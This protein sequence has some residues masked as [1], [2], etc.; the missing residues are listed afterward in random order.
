[1]EKHPLHMKIPD[2]QTSE[3]VTDAVEKKERLT[4][5][6]LPNDPAARIEAYMGRL[7]KIFL[8]TDKRVRERNLEMLRDNTYDAFIIRP[9]E[10]PESYFELQRK[11]ARERG[12]AVEEIPQNVRDQMIETIIADQKHSLD[13]WVDYLTSEDAVYPTWFKYFV[14]RNI[15]G[16]SQY[17]KALGKFKD[18]TESTVAPYPDVYREP[19]AQICDIYEQVAANNK[20]LKTDPEIQ[21]EFSKSFPKL[22]AELITKSLAS[23]IENKEEISGQWVKY[24]QGDDGGAKRLFAS[25]EGK[26]TGWCTAGRSTAE[27]QIESGDFYVYYTNDK[28]GVPAQPRVAIRMD[29]TDKIGEVRGIL[30][31]QSLEPIMQDT[32]DKK[33]QEFGPEADR[34]K[35]KSEDMRRMTEI[36]K[37]HKA[38][39]ALTRD[40]LIFLYEINDKIEGFGYGKDSRIEEIRKVRH[41]AND[42]PAIFDCELEDIARNKEEI[43]KTTKAYVGELFP[44]I[45]KTNIEHIYT[46][47]PEGKIERYSIETGKMTK[48]ETEAEMKDQKI[49]ISSYAQDFMNSEDFQV[50]SKSE[51]LNLV[52]LTVEGMGLRGG[53]T[54]EQIYKRAEELGLELCPPEA[55]PLLRLEYSGGDWM[56]IAMKQII[57]RDGCPSVFALGRS[58]GG[59]EL[60]AHGAEPR[61]T[62]GGGSRWVV[63]SRK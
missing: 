51:Q 45:F 5:K 40:E 22:Y 24:N 1:M 63:V 53:A 13:N 42:L 30:Q 18:R 48:E 16:L 14:F 25:L 44:G 60:G 61:E 56:L 20:K 50:S 36:E 17:D 12:Q 39:E 41:L 34:Y 28:N 58:A 35:K 32:L 47:F 33:L 57:D 4:D 54:T 19:L 55:G 46:T 52:R 8:N 21:R 62:W 37:K 7:E 38:G 9:E 43:T 10:V 26:G 11:V 6:S 27:A 15:I 2:L 49:Y 23:Q 29:G 3:E 59:L 31:H